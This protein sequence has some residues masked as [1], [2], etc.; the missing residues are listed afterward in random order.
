MC[1]LGDIIIISSLKLPINNSSARQYLFQHVVGRIILNQSKKLRCALRNHS[2]VMRL[3]GC[4]LPTMK[5]QNSNSTLILIVAFDSSI[6]VGFVRLLQSAVNNYE[7]LWNRTS[8]FGW[9]RANV[10]WIETPVYYYYYFLIIF[11]L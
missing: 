1:Q 2:S 3:T 10:T 9:P 6:R 7:L 8:F 11:S 5:Y 4:C